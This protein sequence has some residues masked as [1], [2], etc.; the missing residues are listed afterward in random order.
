MS[1]QVNLV[2]TITASGPSAAALTAAMQPPQTLGGPGVSLPLATLLAQGLRV[3][4]DAMTLPTQRTVSL[5]FGPSTPAAATA[6]LANDAT[7]ASVTVTAAGIDYVL[8][9]VISFTG[10]GV[11]GAPIDTFGDIGALQYPKAIAYL[12]VQG[13]SVQFAGSGYNPATTIVGF[14]GGLPPALMLEPQ[15]SRYWFNK[16]EKP[17]Q[18]PVANG[19]PY[20]VN[21]LGIVSKG[22]NYGPN[23]YLVFEGQL[24]E[25]GHEARAV[26]T[27]FGPNG[28]IEGVLLYDPGANYITPPT[29]TVID[30]AG[31]NVGI[32]T[33]QQ[34]ATIVPLMGAGT[35]ATATGITVNGSGGVTGLTGLTAGAGYVQPPNIVLYDTSGA[36]SGGLF[37]ARMGVGA[38]NVTYKGRGLSTVPTVVLTPFFKSMF[39]DTSDQTTP[40]YNYPLLFALKQAT[41]SQVVPSPPA[42]I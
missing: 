28:E 31:V 30:P 37:N 16:S 15:G 38:I 25:G 20:A 6:V 10:G 34:K 9:P 19:P 13:E 33:Q 2:Y 7:L 40:F 1:D 32:S 36:G 5:A 26:I 42:L 11:A 39:P 35:P 24:G 8:P 3:V 4:G 21:Q 23:T 12:D 17:S 27:S 29:I 22:R 14:V 41:A 18:Y